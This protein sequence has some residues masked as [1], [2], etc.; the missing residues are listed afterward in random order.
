M[1][2]HT[3]SRRA[4]VGY[5]RQGSSNIVIAIL[6]TGTALDHPD[7]EGKFVP[8]YD[9]YNND[10]TPYDDFGHGTIAAGIAAASERTTAP[11]S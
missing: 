11:K 3:G 5:H 1:E 8:G 4:G 2:R 7:L 10:D 9:F 6:D